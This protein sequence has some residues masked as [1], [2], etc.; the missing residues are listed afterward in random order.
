[1]N[2]NEVRIVNVDRRHP[3]GNLVAKYGDSLY[4]LGFGHGF[5][6][7]VTVVSF[8]CF[9]GLYARALRYRNT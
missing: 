4:C 1:M 7:G 6:S 5:F 8:A 9:M 3:I 2:N